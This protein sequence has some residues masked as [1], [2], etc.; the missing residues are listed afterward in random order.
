MRG[1]SSKRN[2]A[3][4]S[5]TRPRVSEPEQTHWLQTAM[6]IWQTCEPWS[7]QLQNLPILLSVTSRKQCKCG[8]LHW[9]IPSHAITSRSMYKCIF[10]ES[11]TD[12][13]C[14]HIVYFLTFLK[15]I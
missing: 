2:S 12:L 9:G 8:S 14:N 5:F 6:H 11:F 13:L 15:I 3:P 7:V 10:P 4:S 1:L